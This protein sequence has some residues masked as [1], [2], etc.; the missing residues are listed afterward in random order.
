[1]IRVDVVT[2]AVVAALGRAGIAFDM[3][4]DAC[5]AVERRTSRFGTRA[6]LRTWLL[7][8]PLLLHRIACCPRTI[9][10]PFVMT[11]VCW[12][13]IVTVVCV[14]H[15]AV[16]WLCRMR[17]RAPAAVV[18]GP[19]VAVRTGESSMQRCRS[20][21]GTVYVCCTV[22]VAA[23]AI[24]PSLMPRVTAL[25]CQ[26][27]CRSGSLAIAAESVRHIVAA[28][29]S[30][31]APITAMLLMSPLLLTAAASIDVRQRMVPTPGWFA[32]ETQR[33]KT[34]TNNSHR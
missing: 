11:H 28:C 7:Q 23:M 20:H 24:V 12:Y 33:V 8:C 34:A 2:A 10:R 3:V 1:M 30:D 4:L 22:A 29:D 14:I 9:R 6:S 18:A 13:T 17:Q 32:E 15:A 27:C 25:G 5:P 19:R 26:L 21:Q 16:L 31:A